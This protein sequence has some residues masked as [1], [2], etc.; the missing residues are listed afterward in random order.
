[1]TRSKQPTLD[2]LLD[3]FDPAQHRHPLMLD[4]P[5][6]GSETGAEP[7]EIADLSD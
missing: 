1:M 2:E 7:S 5:P 6:I 3:G 4:F